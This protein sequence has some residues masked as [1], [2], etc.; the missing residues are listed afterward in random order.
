MSRRVKFLSLAL[1]LPLV[2]LALLGHV[3]GFASQPPDMDK[4]EPALQERLLESGETQVRFI[5]HLASGA[6]L[7]GELPAAKLPRRIA[8]VQRLQQTAASSQHQLLNSLRQLQDSGAVS[9]VRPLWIVNAI[10]VEGHGHIVA[11]LAQRSDITRISLD[12]RQQFV[13]LPDLQPQAA[14]PRGR[15]GFPPPDDPACRRR[16]RR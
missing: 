8:L 1:S 7:T 4:I 15:R 3:A 10:I 16:P 14:P 2:L 6:D 9:L 5:V 13:H 12:A 11:Q